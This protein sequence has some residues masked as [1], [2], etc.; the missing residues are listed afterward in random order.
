MRDRKSN[1]GS[2]VTET[3]VNFFT[4]WPTTS[5]FKKRP[6]PR[7]SLLNGSVAVMTHEIDLTF[8]MQLHWMLRQ[9]QTGDIWVTCITSSQCKIRIRQLSAENQNKETPRITVP[10]FNTRLPE[11]KS[12]TVW[13]FYMKQINIFHWNVKEWKKLW[14]YAPPTA[15]CKCE[16]SFKEILNRTY[17]NKFEK[18][19][20][21]KSASVTA[22]SVAVQL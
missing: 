19:E 3:S 18:N 8:T 22:L 4:N 2:K 14:K 17:T 16:V 7:T 21:K 1:E 9:A 6:V 15:S 20:N 5:S 10:D 11:G 12:N 13:N